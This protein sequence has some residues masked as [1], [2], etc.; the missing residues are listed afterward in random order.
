MLAPRAIS[1]L[2]QSTWQWRMADRSGVLLASAEEPGLDP[3]P[4]AA[5][6]G[7]GAGAPVFP[8]CGPRSWKWSVRPAHTDT[9]IHTQTHARQ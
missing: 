8:L 6:P 4:M 2:T 7:G 1:S 5:G 9:H 3:A